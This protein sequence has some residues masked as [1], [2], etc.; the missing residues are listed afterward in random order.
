MRKNG[1]IFTWQQWLFMPFGILRFAIYIFTLLIM[2][3]LARGWIGIL[4]KNAESPWFAF[5]MRKLATIQLILMGVSSFRIHGKRPKNFNNKIFIANHIGLIDVLVFFTLHSPFR[6]V[7]KDSLLNIPFFGYMIQ[8]G[9]GVGVSRGGDNSKAIQSIKKDFPGRPVVVF[10]EGTTSRGGE[11]LQFKSF[12][13]DLDIPIVPVVIL[14]GSDIADIASGFP[15]HHKRFVSTPPLPGRENE[16]EESSDILAVFK[17]FLRFY[18]PLHV[19]FL[20]ETTLKNPQK[21]R[22]EMA[23]VGNFILTDN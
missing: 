20:P 12:V 11:L 21:I 19:H 3:I 8:A 23:S 5:A 4:K 1:G 10:P 6:F 15:T 7:A 22:Q 17:L 2:W 13:F 16:S 14:H 9:G 18:E